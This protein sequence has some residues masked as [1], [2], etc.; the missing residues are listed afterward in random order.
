MGE[1]WMEWNGIYDKDKGKCMMEECMI[2]W[3]GVGEKY[4]KINEQPVNISFPT[5]IN[6]YRSISHNVGHK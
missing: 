1:S 2:V 6:H 5:K 4:K 3:E